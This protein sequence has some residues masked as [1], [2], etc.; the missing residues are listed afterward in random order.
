MR[1]TEH[2]MHAEADAVTE[3]LKT[4]IVPSGKP[5]RILRPRKGGYLTFYNSGAVLYYKV[6]F[7]RPGHNICPNSCGDPA[8]RNAIALNWYEFSIRS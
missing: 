8:G 3:K 2:G 7:F 1:N 5:R 6:Q 4:L